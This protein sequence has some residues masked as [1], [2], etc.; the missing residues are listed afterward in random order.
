MKLRDSQLDTVEMKK[1]QVV[2]RYKYGGVSYRVLTS[3][4]SSRLD[5]VKWSQ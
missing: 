4:N 3:K 1:I 5:W 2:E